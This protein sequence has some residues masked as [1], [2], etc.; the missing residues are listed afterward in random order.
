[1]NTHENHP[2][3]DYSEENRIAYVSLTAIIAKADGNLEAK[4]IENIKQFCVQ[5]GISANNT[6][7]II[8]SLSSDN[9]NV[10]NYITEI[11]NSDLKFTL[12][13]DMFF[14]A[15]VDE[16]LAETEIN[17]INAIAQQLNIKDEQ[18]NA[19]HLY[20]KTINKIKGNPKDANNQAEIN[21]AIKTLENVN[22]PIAAV[23]NSSGFS[24]WD[25]VAFGEF[26]SIFGGAGAAL[27]GV[28]ALGAGTYYGV[29]WL[30]KKIFG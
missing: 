16:V 21:D 20:V 6:E 3:R 13:T 11:S 30:G 22:I 26:L 7:K 8:A 5:I 17:E 12:V 28:L 10:K 4:E 24:G 25:V 14:L 2:L 9:D 27:G 23:K 29:K 1:M 18:V 15:Y 19:I